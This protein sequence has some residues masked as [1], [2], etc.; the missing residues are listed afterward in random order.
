MKQSSSRARSP[1]MPTGSRHTMTRWQWRLRRLLTAGL[2]DEAQAGVDAARATG[3]GLGEVFLDEAQGRILLARGEAAQALPILETVI[4]TAA[5]RE[6]SPGRVAGAY[7][8]R[9]G[10][11]TDR[12]SRRTQRPN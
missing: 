7:A 1:R 6:L 4:R 5:A 11:R 3:L 8:R 2:L 12:P 10:A 9:G